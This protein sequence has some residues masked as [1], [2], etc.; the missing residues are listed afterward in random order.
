MLFFPM[1]FRLIAT[2]TSLVLTVRS[3]VIAIAAGGAGLGCCYIRTILAVLL[4]ILA[5]VLMIEGINTIRNQ[6][7]RVKKAS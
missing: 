6:F 2:V 7:R 3:N 1:I 4:I 5:V